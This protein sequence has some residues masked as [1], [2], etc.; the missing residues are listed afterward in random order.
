MATKPLIPAFD[1]YAKVSAGRASEDDPVAL[2]VWL[3]DQ[4]FGSADLCRLEL[5]RP[6]TVDNAC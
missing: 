2:D 6:A 1:S 3:K 5:C 4:L